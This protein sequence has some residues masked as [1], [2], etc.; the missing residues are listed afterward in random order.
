MS[1]SRRQ[2]LQ[3][4]GGVA[5]ASLMPG[6]AQARDAA[7]TLPVPPL[8][9]AKDGQPLFLSLQR[10][11]WAFE[12]DHRSEVWSVNGVY[13]APTVRVKR[14]DTVKLIYQN[15]LNE[16]VAM[17]VSGL[18]VPGVLAGGAPRMLSA[19][20][21]WSPVLPVNQPAATCWYHAATPHFM[22]KQV[23]NGLVGMWLI[24][25]EQSA[26]LPL[27]NHYGVD[28]FPLIIQDKHL[29][30][31]GEQEYLAPEDGG[32]LGDTLLVNGVANPWVDVSRGWVR[33]RLLNASNARRYTLTLSD[34]RPF[35]V[36]AGDLGLLPEPVNVR[37][38]SLAPGERREIVIDMSQDKEVT[39]MAG[40]EASLLERLKSVFRP[41]T[42]L[43]SARV[44]TLRPTGLLPLMTGKLPS[45]LA[46]KETEGNVP[47]LTREFRL[48]G[49]QPGINGTLLDLNRID[50]V[51]RQGSWERWII[52]ADVPQGFHIQGVRF[53]VK[54]VN[55]AP[56]K[57]ED[58]GWKDT[59]WVEKS[60]ELMVNFPQPS[61]AHFPFL[62]YSTT[63]EMAD[64]GS[65]G[66]LL[67]QPA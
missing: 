41:S 25:D 34:G 56:V 6:P 60:V 31:F 24:E 49:D 52:H 42:R 64:Q 30:S 2:F 48:G 44:L 46:G 7:R 35:Q 37:Q 16:P 4:S 9:E 1:L 27:P 5:C 38:L 47:A 33:L 11:H 66:Q 36:I 51:V 58:Q 29:N 57:P 23:Y 10:S 55:G 13:P 50:T 18:L 59:V 26:A 3:L 65:A 67:V 54:R 21:S 53:L 14:G 20:S 61:Q 62:Y 15:R 17:M 28:D 12:P 19:G 63:L 32:F 22:A 43:L 39:L 8:L 45:R 40:K